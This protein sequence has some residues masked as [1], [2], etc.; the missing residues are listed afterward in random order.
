MPKLQT[1]AGTSY[2]YSNKDI[3]SVC[4]TFGSGGELKTSGAIQGGATCSSSAKQGG[5]GNGGGSGTSGGSSTSSGSA[6][7]LGPAPGSAFSLLGVVLAI[8]GVF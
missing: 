3:S 6:M 8:F 2:I 7:N 1:V 5:A 4:N